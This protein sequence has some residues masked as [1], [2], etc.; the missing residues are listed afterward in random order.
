MAL[1]LA[2]SVS[3][4]SLSASFRLDAAWSAAVAACTA[5]LLASSVRESTSACPSWLSLSKSSLLCAL[6][7]SWKCCWHFAL[8]NDGQR[9]DHR[10]TPVECTVCVCLLRLTTVCFLV[11]DRSASPRLSSS[12]R[13]TTSF[14]CGGHTPFT[15]LSRF[16]VRVGKMSC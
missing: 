4:R 10:L 1:A 2:A 5:A 7:F 12:R 15:N 8:S 9:G 11:R 6:M 14:V 13:L 3:A 16:G